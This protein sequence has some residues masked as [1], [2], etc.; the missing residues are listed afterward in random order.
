MFMLE[1]KGVGRGFTNFYTSKFFKH[2]RT[3][4]FFCYIAER[5]SLGV[6]IPLSS[7]TRWSEKYKST[8]IFKVNFKLILVA[9]ASLMEDISSETRGKALSLKAAFEKPS[10]TSA[11]SLT[12]RYP[13]LMEPLA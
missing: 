6:D 8:R 2:H 10:V 4:K 1:G 5:L 7:P 12:G 9:L 11:I 13:A 3:P